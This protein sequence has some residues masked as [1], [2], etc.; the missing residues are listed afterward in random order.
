MSF[1]K[2]LV[3]LD[4]VTVT[5]SMKITVKDKDKRTDGDQE[6]MPDSI[7]DFEELFTKIN[8]TATTRGDLS[9]VAAT[10]INLDKDT[11][12]FVAND[13]GDVG[14]GLVEL[15]FKSVDMASKSRAEIVARLM[16]N[17]GRKKK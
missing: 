1:V 13:L 12:N 10:R 9:I 3:T 11:Y 2:D 7:I 6:I 16:P 4:V 8:G 5:G 15:H 17:W 14:K